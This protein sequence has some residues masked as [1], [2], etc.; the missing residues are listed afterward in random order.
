MPGDGIIFTAGHGQTTL[1]AVGEN[2][3]LLSAVSI[4]QLGLHEAA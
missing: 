2:R 4:V 1:M 3:R